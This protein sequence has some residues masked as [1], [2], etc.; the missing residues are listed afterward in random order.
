MRIAPV[1]WLRV[2]SCAAMMG[3][4]CCLTASAEEK[5]PSRNLGIEGSAVFVLP[6]ADYQVRSLDDSSEILLYME[7]VS[8]A[9]GGGYRVV[10]RYMGFEPGDYSLANYLTLPDG[11]RA[12]ELTPFK[13]M[14]RSEL[15]G[16]HNGQLEKMEPA[17]FPFMGGYRVFLGSLAVIWVAGI[18]WFIRSSRKRNVVAV[19][20]EMLTEPSFAERIR[21]LVEA[22]AA[23]HISLDEQTLLE[24]LLM[25][26]WREKLEIAEPRMADAIGVLKK[27]PLAGEILRAMERWLHQA[28]NASPS[29]INRLLEPYHRQ[30]ATVVES[31]VIA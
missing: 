30:P 8:P 25:G 15:P 21:P 2:I 22:A 10:V 1:R 9:D 11:S 20:V 18:V 17:P 13:L 3:A 12:E 27:H 28:G 19:A 5:Q 4:L 14:V 24:R 6:R 7:S 23:G 29:E 16:D 26:F 31:E